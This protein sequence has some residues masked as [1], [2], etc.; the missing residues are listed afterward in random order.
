M[1]DLNAWTGALAVMALI[2]SVVAWV[3][4]L[5]DMRGDGR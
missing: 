3:A 5:V 2:P 1:T 4:I